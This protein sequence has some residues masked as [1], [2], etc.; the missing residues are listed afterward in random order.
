MFTISPSDFSF[1]PAAFPS[2]FPPSF[3]QARSPC[4]RH[5]IYHLRHLHHSATQQPSSPSP[6]HS[7][8]SSFSSSSSSCW[9]SP[10]VW[11]SGE[12]CN[13]YILWALMAAYLLLF[14]TSCFLVFFSDH[15][16]TCH[17]SPH[18]TPTEGAGPQQ[19]VPLPNQGPS[20]SQC[21]FQV[22]GSF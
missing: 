12:E 22:R 20:G 1:I 4:S 19:S 21:K 5:H 15:T 3:N 7:P 10:S 13:Q 14:V 17:C 9:Y 16:T 2:H 18:N 11:P 6:P 8:S